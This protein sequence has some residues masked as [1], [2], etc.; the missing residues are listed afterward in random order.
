LVRLLR[1]KERI[2]DPSLA[3]RIRSILIPHEFTR[4][5]DI[6]EVIFSTAE[7][8][9]AD[10]PE[11][12]EA[13][14]T[15]ADA[16]AAAPLPASVNQNCVKRVESH[17]HVDLARRSRTV[18]IDESKGC[19]VVCLVSKEHL[20]VP[21]FFWFGFHPYH[22]ATLEEAREAYIALGCASEFTLLLIPYRTFAPWLEGMNVTDN[23]GRSFR[24]VQISRRNDRLELHQ[25][26]GQAPIDVT[27]YLVPESEVPAASF[28]AKIPARNAALS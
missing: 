2:D 27:S 18:Y 6:V 9:R 3:Q 26:D 17:L 22:R 14:G 20:R 10:Q 15:E 16:Q 5:D 8:A 21:P 4:L 23:P 12:G 11:P 7:D 24:H 19:S 13:P 1:V 28:G 25:K